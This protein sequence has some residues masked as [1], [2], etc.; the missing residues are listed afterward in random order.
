MKWTNELEKTKEKL[1]S[2]IAEKEQEL[3]EAVERANVVDIRKALEE[4]ERVFGYRFFKGHTIRNAVFETFLKN[5]EK[6]NGVTLEDVDHDKGSS[7]ILRT[8]KIHDGDDMLGYLSIEKERIQ[9][10]FERTRVRLMDLENKIKN[11]EE[12]I[13][14]HK[15]KANEAQV[16]LLL[17]VDEKEKD[18]YRAQ[19]ERQERLIEMREKNIRNAKL[20]IENRPEHLKKNEQQERRVQEIAERHGFAFDNK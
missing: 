1:Q 18:K 12:E 7:F 15:A 5:V 14:S 17:A 2:T 19:M 16:R 8:L 10:Y 11:Y 9:V 3:T 4:L 13:V 6:A 20:V